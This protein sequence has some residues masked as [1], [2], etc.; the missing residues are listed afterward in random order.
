MYFFKR[1]LPNCAK[2][3]KRIVFPVLRSKVVIVCRFSKKLRK[4][5]SSRPQLL[6]ALIRGSHQTA[7]HPPHCRPSARLP[8]LKTGLSS[9]LKIEIL[10]ILLQIGHVSAFLA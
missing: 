8:A 3:K 4:C 10:A 6:E 1:V 9:E 2:L 7:G 5:A